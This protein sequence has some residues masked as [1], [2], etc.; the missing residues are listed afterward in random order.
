MLLISVLQTLING[1]GENIKTKYKNLCCTVS[2]HLENI[3]WH[4]LGLLHAQ[5]MSC[6]CGTPCGNILGGVENLA[7]K[8]NPQGIYLHLHNR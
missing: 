3:G 7:Q 6:M 2:E 4:P 5:M 1:E 8:T